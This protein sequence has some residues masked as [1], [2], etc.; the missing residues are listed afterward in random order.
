MR[1]ALFPFGSRGDVQPMVALGKTLRARGVEVVVGCAASY[2]D[3]VL[4]HGLEHA[5]VGGDIEG[6]MRTHG[7]AFARRPVQTFRAFLRFLD[8]EVAGTFAATAEAA[9]GADVM[10]AASLQLAGPSVA[11]HL[12]LPYRTLLYCPQVLPSSTYPPLTVPWMGLPR[13]VNAVMWWA[14]TRA[15]NLALRKPVLRAR[16]RWGLGGFDDVV[17]HLRTLRPVV[18]SDAAL[19]ALAAD[20]DGAPIHAPALV[21]QD[22]APLPA[23][24]VRFLDDGPA[25]VYVGFGSMGAQ[26]PAAAAR[27][28]VDAAT[29]L[30]VRVVAASGWGG[31]SAGDG[32]IDAR[33]SM[34]AVR[35]SNHA[36]L[37]PRCA[38]VVHHGGAG[39]TQAAARAGVPQLVVAHTADQH[40]W[41]HRV[42]A[43]GLGPPPLPRARLTAAR[44]AERIADARASST[45][46]EA[47]R[48]MAARIGPTTG[49]GVVADLLLADAAAIRT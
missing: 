22:D 39:T 42:R 26:D 6:F 11:A 7:E 34:F 48:A 18:C 35:Q 45:Y 41:A 12:G 37:F 4:A 28:V 1:V 29:R 5:P 40:W 15:M 31:L 49:N 46:V 30:G 17:A 2:R 3:F 10:A 16:A 24:L 9:A 32:T 38:L 43:A 36:R 33:A 27:A 21:L 8:D 47:A 20:V 25:P 44:L 19:G 14:I 13:P 23:D